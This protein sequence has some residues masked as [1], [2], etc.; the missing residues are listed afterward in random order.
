ML[1]AFIAGIATCFFGLL[2]I[3]KVQKWHAQRSKGSGS[4]TDEQI[5]T[6]ETIVTVLNSGTPQV[7]V[8]N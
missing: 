2:A 5:R 4:G 7:R 3:G 6:G 8:L 1:I